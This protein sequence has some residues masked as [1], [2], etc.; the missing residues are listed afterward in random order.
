MPNLSGMK[1]G[2]IIHAGLLMPSN[3][4]GRTT[5]NRFSRPITT[6]HQCGCG[7]IR[8]TRVRPPTVRNCTRPGSTRRCLP[9]W[10]RRSGWQQPCPL[11]SCRVSRPATCPCRTPRHSWRHHGCWLAAAA[12]FSMPV[13]R[14]AAK[15]AIW[16]SLAGTRPS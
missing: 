1:P 12:E 14:Q 4:T 10:N 9:A 3:K 2:I 11:Q 15:A 7:S 16:L 8:N 13:P 5:G 6:G